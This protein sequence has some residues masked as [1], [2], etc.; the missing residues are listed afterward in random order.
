MVVV[1]TFL[2]VATPLM[3]IDATALFEEAHVV[4]LVISCVELSENV[5]KTENASVVPSGILVSTGFTVM[6][7]IE[8]L[9]TF[10]VAEPC[11]LPDLAVIVDCPW[12]TPFAKP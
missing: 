1:P 12:A 10:K 7:F 8:A 4:V 2:A 11:T 5:P 9:V 3:V 6:E